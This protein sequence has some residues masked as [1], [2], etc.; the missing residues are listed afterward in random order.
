MFWVTKFRM[1][2]QQHVLGTESDADKEALLRFSRAQNEMEQV[3]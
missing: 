2:V 3:Y 1:F